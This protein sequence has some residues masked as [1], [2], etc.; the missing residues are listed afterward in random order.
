MHRKQVW[1]VISQ[2]F[3]NKGEETCLYIQS[4]RELEY[5]IQYLAWI[6]LIIFQASKLFLK[7]Y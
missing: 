7:R 3:R 6:K 4:T 1:L 5:L 2:Q